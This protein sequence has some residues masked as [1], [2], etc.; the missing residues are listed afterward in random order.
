[1]SAYQNERDVQELD[2]RGYYLERYRTTAPGEQEWNT[3]TAMPE[4]VSLVMSGRL[5]PGSRVLDL[6]CG[7]GTESVFLAARGFEVSALDISPNA[8]GRG[9]RLADVY[10]VRVDWRVGDA[11]DLPFEAGEF[12]V[13]TDRGCFHCLHG[14]ERA[15]FSEQVARVLAPGG[16]YVLRCFASQRPGEPWPDVSG[17]FVTRTFGVGSKDLWDTFGERFTCERLELVSSFAD[18][19]RPEPYGWFSLWYRRP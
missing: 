9:R 4:L 11:L 19:D 1:M 13:V 7:I 5:R 16:L 15:A 14:H 17:D 3:G 8:V 6:G 18:E 10:G 2:V 12:E